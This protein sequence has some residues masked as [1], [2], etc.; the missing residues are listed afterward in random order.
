[1]FV[2]GDDVKISRQTVEQ[3]IADCM[4]NVADDAGLKARYQRLWKPEAAKERRA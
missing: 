1:M 3:V 4:M 2:A